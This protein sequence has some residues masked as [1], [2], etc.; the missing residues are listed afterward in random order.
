MCDD[1]NITHDSIRQNGD[2]LRGEKL[3]DIL[4]FIVAKIGPQIGDTIVI[5]RTP[6]GWEAGK[7]HKA[8]DG[9]CQ[10]PP[11]P[12]CPAVAEMKVLKRF[13]R[14]IIQDYCWDLGDPDGGDIQDFAEKLGL[15]VPKIASSEESDP[16]R[17]IEEGD[18]IFV[19][20]ERLKE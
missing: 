11:S 19:F 4:A 13:A 8:I 6:F 16:E 7:R 20:A 5:A 17:D 15:I 18:K 12:N 9:Y 1:I 3:E 2:S 14:E 10:P